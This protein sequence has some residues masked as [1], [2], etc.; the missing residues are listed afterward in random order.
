MPSVQDRTQ[1][2]SEELYEAALT[3]PFGGVQSELPLSEIEAY[4][5]ADITNFILRKG[6]AYTR[7]GWTALSALP[8]PSNEPILASPNFYNVDGAQIQCVIT[9]TRLLQYV[10]GGW[11]QITGPAFGGNSS[12][13]FSWDVLNYKLCFSQGVDIIW[14]WDGV[15]AS[16]VQTNAGAPPAKYLA[17]VGLHLFAV[18][19]TYPNRYYWS[20]IGDPTDWSGYTSG[21][22]DIANNLGPINGIIKLGVYGYGF[23]QNGIMQL[24]PTGV[25][26]APWSFYSIINTPQGCVAPY[27]LCRMDDNGIEFAVYLGIDNVYTFDGSSIQPIGDMP[28]GNNRQRLGARSRILADVLT[29]NPQTIYGLASYTIAGQYFRAYWLVIPNVAVW[30]YNFDEGNWTR[31]TYNKTI[32]SIG[33]FFKNNALE[34][35]NLVGTIQSQSWSPATL[36]NNNPFEG[37]LLGCSDGTAAYIDFTNYSEIGASLTSGKLIFGDRRHRKAIKKFRLSFIDLG[38]VTFTITLSN[39]RGQVE[40]HS[41]TVGSGSGDVLN[42]VQ[43]FNMPGLRFQYIVYVPAGS[44]T[45]IFELAPIYDIGGEQRGGLLEN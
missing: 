18:N 22:N 30:V 29:S 5:F 28:V 14:M 4:G 25:G 16:Y 27:S 10:N 21:L 31:F 17:E 41:F 32:V 8:A 34:I 7:P 9:P 44:A 37:L 43:E 23:H 38:S 26:T 40:A 1:L 11:T 33:N 3:G 39:E 13:L 2:R 19:P 24:V 36:L 42:Y 15:A 45:G 35:M 6:A 20:G 12:E